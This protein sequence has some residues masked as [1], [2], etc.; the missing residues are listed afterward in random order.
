[1]MVAGAELVYL[2][3]AVLETNFGPL[4]ELAE[5]RRKENELKGIVKTIVFEELEVI[6]LL[7]TGS[8]KYVKLF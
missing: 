8:S 4:E 5:Q 3:R 7:G 2:D 1:M 6:G